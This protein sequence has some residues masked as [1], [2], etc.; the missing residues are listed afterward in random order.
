MT[1]NGGKK[2][3]DEVLDRLFMKVSW[4]LY[5]LEANLVALQMYFMQFCTWP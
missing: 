3:R 2:R 5:H 1:E 4:K